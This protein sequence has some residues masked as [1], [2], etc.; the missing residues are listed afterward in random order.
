LRQPLHPLPA[1]QLPPRPAARRAGGG[2]AAGAERKLDAGAAGAVHPARAGGD[3]ARRAVLHRPVLRHRAGAAVLQ[4]GAVG[5][6]AR[7]RLLLVPAAYGRVRAGAVHPQ[8]LWLRVFLAE[9]AVAGGRLGA[10]VDLPGTDRHA[11]VLADV[12][13]TPGTLAGG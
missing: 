10:A 11:A 6:A 2:A 4:P 12:P 1:S 9:L 5:H 13:R 7:P 8:W 3:H